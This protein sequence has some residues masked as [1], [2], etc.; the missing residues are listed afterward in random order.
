MEHVNSSTQQ[1]ASAS[2]ELSATAEELSAQA[3][4]LQEQ[5]AFFRTSTHASAPAE[6]N[7]SSATR[8]PQASFHAPALRGQT[9]GAQRRTGAGSHAGSSAP[10]LAG[11]VDEGSFGRF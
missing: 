1:N 6:F 2:E 11:E 4:Q 9:V 3:S 5:M 8:R 10:A 7:R